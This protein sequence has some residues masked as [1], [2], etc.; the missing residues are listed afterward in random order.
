MV[1]SFSV[2]KSTRSLPASSSAFLMATLSEFAAAPQI[3]ME[4]V[5]A[6]VSAPPM[7][8]VPPTKAQVASAGRLI[9]THLLPPGPAVVVRSVHAVL[10]ASGIELQGAVRV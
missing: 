4:E 3:R 6:E 9:V 2:P 1:A 7:I 8:D 10:R 5:I